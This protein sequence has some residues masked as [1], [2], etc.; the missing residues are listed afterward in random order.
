MYQDNMSIII[1]EKNGFSSIWNKTKHILLWY[2]LIEYQ[3][4]LGY[5]YIKYC[6]TKEIMVYHFTK[7]LQEE[8][9]RKF[10]EVI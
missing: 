6:P 1:M 2:V 8:I 9:F 3:I 4:K 10:K 7:P 5:M